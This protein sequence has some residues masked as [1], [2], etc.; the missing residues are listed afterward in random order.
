MTTLDQLNVKVT[1][2]TSGLRSEF[3]RAEQTIKSLDKQSDRL[4]RSN[5]A[6]AQSFDEQKR[7]VDQL[8]R[9]IDP[10][11]ASSKQYESAVE[12]LNQA[13]KAGAITQAQHTQMAQQAA[14][15]YLRTADSTRA[16]STGMASMAQSSGLGAQRLQ[17]V[18]Y[19]LQDIFV[20]M[21]MGVPIMRTLGQQLPQMTVGFGA[22]G[23]VVGVLAGVGLPLLSVAFGGLGEKAKTLDEVMDD[24]VSNVDEYES[25]FDRMNVST[26]DLKKKYG[27]FANS[28]YEARLELLEFERMDALKQLNESAKK[29]SSQFE[30]IR[31]VI[32]YD[33]NAS[34]DPFHISALDSKL[35]T[36]GKSLGLTANEAGKLVEAFN[37]IERAPTPEDKINAIDA[38]LASLDSA[39]VAGEE[40]EEPLRNIIMRLQEI[41]IAAADI[42][43]T[44]ANAQ[45]RVETGQVVETRSKRGGGGKRDSTADD[46]QR[47]RDGLMTETEEIKAAYEEQQAIIDKALQKR[48]L[49]NAEYQELEKEL[50]QQFRDELLDIT[51][52]EQEADIERENERHALYIE[53]LQ[54][55]LE[56]QLILRQEYNR[57]IEEEERRHT[58][59]LLTIRQMSAAQEF[60]VVA[61]AGQEILTAIGQSNKKALK[62]AKVFGAAKAL[63]DTYAGAAAALKLPFPQ[64]M[65]AAA[66]IIATGIGFVNSIK[67]VSESGISTGGGAAAG[68]GSTAQQPKQ[69]APGGTLTVQGIDKSS[70]FTGDV[71]QGLAQ[72][73]LEYQRTGGSVVFDT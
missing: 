68:G 35:R 13:L 29:L 2:D 30:E 31:D 44:T 39:V 14:S 17:N 61:G 36:L 46:L 21:E 12:Q 8:R 10:M 63:A 33:M 38:L 67:S 20:Q 42:I 5:A 26:D 55:Q 69:Q 70:L 62:I 57:L 27:E 34:D 9:S 37:D 32:K 56:E 73:L 11:Y 16:M 7:S 28:I 19:Q 40:M 60:A 22:I 41:K 72:E 71:V 51:Q 24:L 25:A 6:L 49:T 15:A 47:L 53:A 43:S 1:G 4:K 54:M 23:A 58:G 50:K 65:A 59:T 52:T 66:S 64:N 3:S 48:L 45:A 18:S